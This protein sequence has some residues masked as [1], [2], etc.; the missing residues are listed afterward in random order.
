MQILI[1]FQ[2]IGENPFSEG[3]NSEGRDPKQGHT[4][5][6]TVV[7]I[8]SALREDPQE[9]G[10]SLRNRDLGRTAEMTDGRRRGQAFC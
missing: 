1:N 9:E 10:N 4:L 7:S 3:E 5:S 2:R 8:S 6:I